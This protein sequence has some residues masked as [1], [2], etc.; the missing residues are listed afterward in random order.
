MKN[1]R[2]GE[3]STFLAEGAHRSSVETRQLAYAE[4]L[5]SAAKRLSSTL[6][7]TRPRPLLR[8]TNLHGSG[9]VYDAVRLD[10]ESI[11]TFLETTEVN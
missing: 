7:I 2:V 10:S 11:D 9:R 3:A 8:K 4:L 1:G 6:I 5:Q